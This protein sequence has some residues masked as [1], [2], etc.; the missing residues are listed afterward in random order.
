MVYIING[1]KRQVFVCATPSHPVSRLSA[2][3]EY[4]TM[5]IRWCCKPEH[6]INAQPSPDL[7]IAEWCVTRWEVRSYRDTTQHLTIV[8]M[9]NKSSL[10]AAIETMIL[11]KAANLWICPSVNNM[12]QGSFDVIINIYEDN[13][14]K[15]DNMYITMKSPCSG[16]SFFEYTKHM[17]DLARITGW[18]E[19]KNCLCGDATTM[20]KLHCKHVSSP[21]G[22]RIVA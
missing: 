14:L 1:R 13:S 8:C 18:S 22:S 2:T 5:A 4:T 21:L 10:S 16:Y 12:I 7:E 17:S 19:T 11:H 9:K 3:M 15:S 6:H 20:Y